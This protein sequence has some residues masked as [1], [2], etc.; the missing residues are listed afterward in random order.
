MSLN[1]ANIKATKMKSQTIKLTRLSPS[2]SPLRRWR[3]PLVCAGRSSSTRE[4]WEEGADEG[5][6]ES[7]TNSEKS[8]WK[9]LSERLYWCE[10]RASLDLCETE[11]WIDPTVSSDPSMKDSKPVNTA[12]TDHSGFHVSGWKSD[13]DKHSFWLHLK[14]PCGV[15]MYTAR[16]RFVNKNQIKPSVEWLHI[17][18]SS[19]GKNVTFVMWT[20]NSVR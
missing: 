19:N 8:S 12:E 16:K 4:E 6:G 20:Q 2:W 1:T 9:V 13:M 11:V 18:T 15:H 3:R 10:R 17:L 7:R 5:G 14:R